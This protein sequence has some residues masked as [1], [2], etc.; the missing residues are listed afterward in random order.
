M[1]TSDAERGAESGGGVYSRMIKAR[2]TILST[3]PVWIA[4]VFVALTGIASAD[5]APDPLDPSRVRWTQLEYRASKFLI[6][7]STQ[8][9][10][11]T[12]SAAE[13]KQALLPPGQ[14]VALQPSGSQVYRVDLTTNIFGQNTS[15]QLWLEPNAAALQRTVL[16]TGR[17][18]RYRNFR[19]TQTGTY[20]LKRYPKPGEE[21]SSW[22]SWSDVTE[23]FYPHGEAA[24]GLVITETSAL[25]YIMSA[26]QLEKPGD[27]LVFHVFTNDALAIVRARVRGVS[28]LMANYEWIKPEAAGRS[29]GMIDALQISLNVK[30]LDPSRGMEAPDFMALKGDLELYLD[31]ASRLVLQ[32]S[33]KAEVV[34]ALDIK[35]RKAVMR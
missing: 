11:T 6:T 2:C 24:R 34:G 9:S 21:R 32:L 7:L 5:A 12:L 29:D 33:G 26:S 16:N 4:I 14:G 35:L 10:L 17:K 28:R 18:H 25:L 15:V 3:M 23:D 1:F 20:S 27:E 8:I 31:P 30:P 22:Q 19:Y 13:A